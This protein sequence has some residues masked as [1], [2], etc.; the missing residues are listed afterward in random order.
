MENQGILF[1]LRNL[2]N[3]EPVLLDMV[4]LPCVTL[5]DLLQS[6]ASSL[7]FFSS[8]MFVEVCLSQAKPD[9]K[10]VIYFKPSYSDQVLRISTD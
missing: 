4:F 1:T 6:L 9:S 7:S 3:S 8:P 2:G 10:W 5:E